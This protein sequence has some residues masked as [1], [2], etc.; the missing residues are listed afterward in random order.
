MQQFSPLES[1]NV[2]NHWEDEAQDFTPWLANQIRS[3]A[4]SELESALNLDLEVIQEEESVGRYS[5]D[6]L[7]EVIEDS[8]KVIIENQLD[9]SDHDHLGKAL[10]YASGI[11]SDIIVWIAPQ[12]SDQHRDAF[13]W[14]NQNSGEGIDL[15][16]I[17]LEVWRIGDSEPAVRLKPITK[18]SEWREK[19]R[20]GDDDLS[21]IKKLQEEFWTQFGDRIA[22]SDTRLTRRKPSP[23]HW[24]N[25]PIGKAGVKL[26]FILNSKKNEIRS[27]LIIKDDAQAY[28]RLLDDR[29]ALDSEI[30]LTLNWK[31]PDETTGKK[32]RSRIYFR[33][34]GDMRDTDRWVDFQDWFIDCGELFHEHFADRIQEL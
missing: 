7:A 23:Q 22:Q 1:Q 5:V 25:N 10:A 11:D 34:S 27:Q 21:E 19:A 32:D 6:I 31:A 29:E 2:R 30:D 18:P 33:K 14:L 15:F 8:R 17:R 24:Y 20:R 16:A 12:F 9:P 28:N 13:Q 3:D 26:S 4:E